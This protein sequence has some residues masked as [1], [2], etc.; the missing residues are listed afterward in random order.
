MQGVEIDPCLKGLTG[1]CFKAR[2]SYAKGILAYRLLVLLV[3]PEAVSRL[4]KMAEAIFEIVPEPISE[5]PPIPEV[6]VEPVPEIP[7]IPEVPEVPVPVIPEVPVPEVPVEPVPEVPVPPG[8]KRRHHKKY[9]HYVRRRRWMFRK[10]R[11]RPGP[12]K[13]PLYT[14]PWSP[15]PIRYSISRRGGKAMPA[16]HKAKIDIATAADHTIIAAVPSRKISISAIAFTVAGET[17]L[18]LKSG[19]TALSGAMDFGGTNEPRGLTH[20]LGEYPLQTAVGEAFVI[21]NSIAVQVSG[22]VSYYLS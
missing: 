2:P 5:I 6:V 17:N 19:S 21:T 11:R 3:P 9:R 18:T 8:I 14:G 12:I 15:G 7:P 4:P 10:L 20:N 13:A 16:I 1:D 22:Y